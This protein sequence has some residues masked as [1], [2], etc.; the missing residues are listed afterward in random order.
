[1]AGSFGAGTFPVMVSPSELRAYF[2]LTSREWDVVVRIGQ[3]MSNSEI[4]AELFISVNSV[5]T[6]IRTAYRRMGCKTRAQAIIWAY[7]YGLVTP[8]Q[9]PEGLRAPT[10]NPAPRSRFVVVAPE[11][12][13]DG[14]A[15]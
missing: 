1:M 7:H 12:G 9:L 4:A 11:S 14:T 6:Y 5:K 15:V 3:G 13:E 8:D 10:I 2:G